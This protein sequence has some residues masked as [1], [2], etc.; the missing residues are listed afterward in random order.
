MVYKILYT[1]NFYVEMKSRQKRGIAAT[2]HTE[3]YA[4]QPELYR[5]NLCSTE[6]NIP[7]PSGVGIRGDDATSV[8]PLKKPG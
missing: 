3:R 6:D 2:L 8:G 7:G 1:K 4:Q 5:N